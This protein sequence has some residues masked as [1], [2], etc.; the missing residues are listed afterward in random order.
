[1]QLR[2]AMLLKGS[3][4]DWQRAEREGEHSG[5]SKFWDLF[6]SPR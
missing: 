2:S 4:R 6:L 1:M 5:D 3:A